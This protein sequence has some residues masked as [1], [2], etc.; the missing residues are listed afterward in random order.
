MIISSNLL[1]VLEWSTLT[2]LRVITENRFLFLRI[3]LSFPIPF[4]YARPLATSVGNA[5]MGWCAAKPC[6]RTCN[7]L[8]AFS[9]WEMGIVHTMLRG[10]WG[11]SA[12]K[13]SLVNK[14]QPR[15][16]AVEYFMHTHTHTRTQMHDVWSTWHISCLPLFGAEQNCLFIV[17]NIQLSFKSG[18][19]HSWSPK[20]GVRQSR[21]FCNGYLLRTIHECIFLLLLLF[22]VFLYTQP[23]TLPFAHCRCFFSW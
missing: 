3:N 14:L 6:M 7:F 11:S 16:W 22:G 23:L 1:W 20:P 4:K 21:I 19:A 9:E 12:R 18:T 2:S 13:A 10:R 5:W 15:L 8:S 17:G